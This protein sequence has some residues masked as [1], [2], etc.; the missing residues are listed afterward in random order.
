MFG[1]LTALEM[2]MKGLTKDA[3]NPEVS[4]QLVTDALAR[5][6]CKQGKGQ[7]LTATDQVFFFFVGYI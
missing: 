7:L 1:L 4:G 6:T 3:P 5:I 2:I